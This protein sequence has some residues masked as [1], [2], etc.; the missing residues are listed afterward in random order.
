MSRALGVSKKSWCI[1]AKEMLAILEAIR[2]WRPY[3]LG[4]K[5]IIQTDQQSLK[6]LLKQKAATLVQQKLLG[7]LMGYEYEILYRPGRDNTAVDGLSRRP[8][9]PMMNYLFVPHVTVWEEIKTAATGDDYIQQVT[10]LAEAQPTGPYT[11]KN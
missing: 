11:T 3:I 4:Q 1:Y 10:T 6:Y 7:K 9:N 5:F 2:M 8:D